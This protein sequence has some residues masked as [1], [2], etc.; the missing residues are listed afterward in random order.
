[1]TASVKLERADGVA[2]VT[3]SNPSIKNGLTRQMALDLVDL[4]DQVDADRSIGS[5]VVT[6]DDGTFCSG[7]DTKTWAPAF[8]DPGTDRAL[9]EA[10]AMYN[11]FYRLGQ[12]EVPTIAAV[13]GAAVGAG[14]NLAMATDLR[15]VAT[16]ARL[17]GGFLRAGIH[18]GG[19]FFTIT[20]RL[21]GREATAAMGLFSEEVS[22]ARA[23][24]LG[25]AWEAVEP[26]AVLDRALEL[27]ARA[28]Q[29]V[30][31]G[32]RALRS[33]RLETAGASMPWAVALEMERGVQAWSQT[34]RLRSLDVKT[35]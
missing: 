33:F 1:M 9:E 31:L 27:A 17:I 20:S 11:A 12:V 4:F 30:P 3:I 34:R 8:S 14:L 13:N 32:R 15:I 29:D 7:A 26:E 24:E 18:P 6:G 35:T 10:D 21:V 25:L 19:G 28:A 5:L 16:N 23:V 22:G 2:V